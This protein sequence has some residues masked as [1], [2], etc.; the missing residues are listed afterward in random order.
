VH[1]FENVSVCARACFFVCKS[2]WCVC[3]WVC[4]C[5]GVGVGV[6]ECGCAYECVS[7][8]VC[9]CARF[10]VAERSPPPRSILPVPFH[11]TAL[12]HTAGR[13]LVLLPVPV[14]PAVSRYARQ[15][16]RG[17]EECLVDDRVPRA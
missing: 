16:V 7:G 10:A 8:C 11:C 1:A 9:V 14:H 5:V 2:V 17:E 15:R 3:T 13:L 6:C 12:H 4:R